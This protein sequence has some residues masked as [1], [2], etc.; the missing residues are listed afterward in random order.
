MDHF[1]I[2]VSEVD[3]PACLLVIER[4]R[5]MEIGEV[6]VISK[7]LHWEG[8]TMKIVVPE[9]QGTNDCKEFP[10]IDV[11]VTFGRVK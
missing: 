10:V 7:N 9:F 8:R 4:L 2:E 1:E 5:L 3:K 6:F 11:V